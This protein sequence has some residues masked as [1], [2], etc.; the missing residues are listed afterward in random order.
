[1]KKIIILIVL[2]GTM[3]MMYHCRPERNYIEEQDAKLQFSLDT[4]YFDTIFTTVG[5][6]TKEFRVYNPHSR[7]IK[8]DAIELAG[9]VGS[10]FRINVDGSPGNRFDN[11]ELAPG[12]S[13]Y[14]FVEATL[15]PNESPDILRIQDSITFSVNGN[16]QDIDLVA[17]G[18]DVH[19]LKDSILDY[20]ATWVADKPYLI[21]G[22]ILVDTLQELTIEKG[23]QIYMH[24]DAGIYILGSMKINGSLEDPVVIQG[25]RLEREFQDDP[26]Y[27][28]QWFG[29]RFL[30]GSH[31]NVVNY[32]RILNGT[33]GLMAD[34]VVRFD[35]PVMTITNTEINRMS[36]V[37]ILGRGTTIKA[38]NTVVGDCGSSC[39]QL[40]YEGSYFFNH[41]TLANYWRTGFSNRK[42]PALFIANYFTYQ[43]DAGKI[44][45]H[46]RDIDTAYF[47]NSIIHGSRNNEILVSKSDEGR[48]HYKFDHILT[49]LDIAEYD[50]IHDRSFTGIINNKAPEFDS[51]RVSY[52]LDSLSPAINAGDPDY[53]LEHPFDFNGIN[54]LADDKPDLG[55]FEKN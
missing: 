31:S 42:T 47:T 29:I 13:M 24:R 30:P 54:R 16:L 11:F 40:L 10:V 50:Y 39:V 35:Q 55:A 32:A 21:I 3:A 19:L 12:D 8:I 48:L 28:G 45:V 26:G 9:G 52:E 53:A 41:C 33:V 36:Y 20:S 22:G 18:Q 5:T 23:V 6:I 34:S 25:D 15:N 43:D 37:G 14:V 51:L 38:W 44:I 7:Y 49:R 4:V 2:A 46:T 27:P 17:W 1:M